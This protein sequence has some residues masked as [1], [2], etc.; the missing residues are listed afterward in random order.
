MCSFIQR[1][2]QPATSGSALG[3]KLEPV[4]HDGHNLIF[5]K[6]MKNYTILK[7]GNLPMQNLIREK[8]S[9]LQDTNRS[10]EHCPNT[11][12]SE[13]LYNMQPLHLQ[14]ISFQGRGGQVGFSFSWSF[15]TIY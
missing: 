5:E 7:N 12:S 3:Q 2:Q 1:G 11:S 4:K 14:L 10:M 9:D 15:I 8:L 13:E 6:K